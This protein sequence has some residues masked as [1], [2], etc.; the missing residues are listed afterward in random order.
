MAQWF[1]GQR[2]DQELV[3][4]PPQPITW[5]RLS[6]AAMLTDDAS[7]IAAARSAAAD[8]RDAKPTDTRGEDAT[9]MLVQARNANA[10][11]GARERRCAGTTQMLGTDAAAPEA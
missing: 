5:Q 9:A 10:T 7:L 3:V 2:R 4:Q 1:E 8:P 11:C 6:G